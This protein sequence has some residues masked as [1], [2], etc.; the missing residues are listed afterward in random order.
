MLPVQGM[1][2]AFVSGLFELDFSF[3]SFPQGLPL[4]LFR[5]HPIY[6]HKC[7]SAFSAGVFWQLD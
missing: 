2:A 6:G 5:K 1:Q 4:T 7:F 3:L